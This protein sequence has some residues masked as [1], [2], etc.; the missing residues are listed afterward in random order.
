[1]AWDQTSRFVKIWTFSILT[2]FW[3]WTYCFNR[4][5]PWLDPPWLPIWVTILY[6]SAVWVSKRASEI[7]YFNGFCTY[8]CLPRSILFCAIKVCVWSGVLMV[9][10]S[11]SI[12]YQA[13]LDNHIRRIPCCDPWSLVWLSQ[14]LYRKGQRFD[15][16]H[17]WT[18]FLNRK[19]PYPPESIAAM[20]NW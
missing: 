9:T 5:T 14:D 4:T 12:P 17:H 13:L 19:P 20:G 6:F 15:S 10:V 2:I 1:M 7:I 16:S 18:P 11:M 3:S 8:T